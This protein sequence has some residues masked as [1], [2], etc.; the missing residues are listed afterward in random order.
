M[1]WNRNVDDGGATF[2]GN[3]VMG[4]G[5]TGIYPTSN[6]VGIALGNTTARWVLVANS[7]DFSTT[8]NV[9]NTVISTTNAVFGGTIAANGSIGTAG[10]VL[11]SGAAGNVYWA[12]GGGSVNQAAQYSWTNTHSFSNTITFSG[13]VVITGSA[14]LDGGPVTY[15]GLLG[16]M[17]TGSFVF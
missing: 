2:L 13:N 16:M 12:T 6:T 15:S 9:G 14:F 4:T 17:R 5:S 7:G 3:V 1:T 10:Q 8:V 11:T